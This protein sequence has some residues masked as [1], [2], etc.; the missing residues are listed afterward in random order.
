MNAQ[1]ESDLKQI[2]ESMTKQICVILMVSKIDLENFHIDQGLVVPPCHSRQ[3]QLWSPRI[4][5]ES[6]L[7]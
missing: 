4:T 2:H 6:T 1:R 5:P 3:P 7:S